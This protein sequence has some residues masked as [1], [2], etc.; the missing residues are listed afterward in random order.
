MRRPNDKFYRAAD[1]SPR[2][3]RYLRTALIAGP[4]GTL[5]LVASS[6]TPIPVAAAAS[7]QSLTI[8]VWDTTPL[9]QPTMTS[10]NQTFERQNP[11]IKINRVAVSYSTY[12]TK[13]RAAIASGTGPDVYQLPA[14]QW[15]FQYGNGMLPLSKYI[16][17]AQ[18]S[19]L[20]GWASVSSGFSA[21][22]SPY[23]L[24]WQIA[25]FAFYYNKKLFSAAG[26]NPNTPPTTWAQLLQDAT[27]L[28]NHNITPIAAGFK[29]GYYLQW[30]MDV[31]S[32]E[33]FTPKQNASFV[34]KPTWTNNS[35]VAQSVEDVQ[36]L[37]KAGDFTPDSTGLDLFT[38]GLPTFASGKAAMV[39]GLLGPVDYWGDFSKALGASNIGVFA[40]PLVPHAAFSSPLLDTKVELGWAISKSSKEPVAAYKYISFMTSPSAQAV[41][42]AQ[43]GVLPNISTA[44]PQTSNPAG[45]KLLALWE[46]GKTYIDPISSA[47]EA[48]TS[49]VMWQFATEVLTGSESISSYLSSIQAAQTPQGKIP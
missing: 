19:Q 37:Y 1:G 5:A 18:R 9:P 47:Y 43:T 6:V 40:P 39:L 22:G 34:Q 7:P 33:L 38:S 31:I 36:Q 41:A 35:V 45:R 24:P 2:Y 42:F 29:D 11:G 16:T 13:V 32:G 17:P 44:R 48:S 25:G 30:F 14:P 49:A 4:I 28:K 12:P 8:T 20:Q 46:A 10:L 3:C 27:T 21:S 23:A 26:L 15:V